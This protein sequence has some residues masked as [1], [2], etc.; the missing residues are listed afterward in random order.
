MGKGRC[1][2][3][4]LRRPPCNQRGSALNSQVVYSELATRNSFLV[5]VSVIVQTV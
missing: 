3:L 1:D 4:Q 2:V 5:S